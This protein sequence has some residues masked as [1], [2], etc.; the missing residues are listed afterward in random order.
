[1]DYEN[2]KR[3]VHKTARE[4]KRVSGNFYEASKLSIKISKKEASIEDKY[5]MIGELVYNSFAHEEPAGD[6]V[7]EL[8]ESISEDFAEIKKMKRKKEIIKAGRKCEV[9][10]CTVSPDE[11]CCPNCGSEL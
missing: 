4:V 9:C 6:K 8:C 11:E 3:T 2:I 5:L 10:G 7:H 1:M